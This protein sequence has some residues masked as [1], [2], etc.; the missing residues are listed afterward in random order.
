MP[1]GYERLTLRRSGKPHVTGLVHR[2]VA[3][4]FIPRSAPDLEVNHKNNVR[5]DNRATNL[6]W[7]TRK[8]NNLH[9]WKQGRLYQQKVTPD[10]LEQI[11]HL[12]TVVGLTQKDVAIQLGIS[13]SLVSHLLR[14]RAGIYH[15]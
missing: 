10:K 8:Q 9:A 11:I 7:V 14:S 4:A 12:Y 3:E 1:N 6:E 13:Q 2:L 5:H 15:G